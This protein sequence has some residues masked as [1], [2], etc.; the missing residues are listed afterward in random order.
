MD[1]IRYYSLDRGIY[2]LSPD[3]LVDMFSQLYTLQNKLNIWLLF[4]FYLTSL[5]SQI[6]GDIKY[7][8]NIHDS[9]K[10]RMWLPTLCGMKV[11]ENCLWRKTFF[12]L[13][14]ST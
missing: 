14:F 5:T 6:V 10:K 9:C 7:S 3:N 13:L 12:F 1:F 8:S 2:S 4:N 11:F